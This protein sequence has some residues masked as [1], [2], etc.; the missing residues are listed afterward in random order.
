MIFLKCRWFFCKDFLL[1]ETSQEEIKR[2][3][4]WRS[5]FITGFPMPIH[6]QWYKIFKQFL[7]S[8]LIWTVIVVL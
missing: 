5:H 3:E 2:R 6:Y 8:L 1:D 4:V 7:A